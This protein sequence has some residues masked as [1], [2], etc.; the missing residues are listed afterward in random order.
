M[1]NWKRIVLGSVFSM[2]GCAGCFY[3]NARQKSFTELTMR[4]LRPVIPYCLHPVEFNGSS[5][6]LIWL[7]RDYKPLGVSGYWSNVDYGA[8]V[9]HHVRVDA[10]ELEVVRTKWKNV[11]AGAVTTYYLFDDA[12]APWGSKAL[13]I[14]AICSLEAVVG[15]VDVHGPLS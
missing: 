8:F 6:R 9:T 14:H 4:A 5:G 13:A 11:G 7:N 10:P 15:R 1:E 2:R 12:S 3:P